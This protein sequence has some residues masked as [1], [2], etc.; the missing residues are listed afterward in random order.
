MHSRQSTRRIQDNTTLRPITLSNRDIRL[1]KHMIIIFAIF[2]S[3]WSPIYILICIDFNAQLSSIIYR[4]LSLLPAL[5][6]LG[7]ITDLFLFNH[8]L[9]LHFRQLFV[10]RNGRI[11]PIVISQ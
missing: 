5:S 10:V 6:L 1:L 9:R 3:G 8:Q 2:L 4:A 7:N 11:Q